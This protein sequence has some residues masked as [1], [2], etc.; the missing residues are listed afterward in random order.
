MGIAIRVV[1]LN[2]ATIDELFGT[3]LKVVHFLFQEPSP[4]PRQPSRLARL[5][6]ARPADPSPLCSAIRFDDD[7]TDVDKAWD[8]LDF[9]FSEG[10]TKTGICRFLTE[11][12][13]VIDND[14]CCSKPRAFRSG[15]V[16]EI[17][18]FFQSLGEQSLRK[19]YLP[20]KMSKIYPGIW[21]RDGDK[22]FE[23]ILRQ[24]SRLKPFIE[25]AA[26]RGNGILISE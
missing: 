23:Y 8:A 26:R 5:F 14:I 12:G 3:P 7:E 16:R 17:S 11:G 4:I 22:G 1:Q 10:R 6:G 20:R 13:Q 19:Y 24:F 18:E 9:L 25:M 21:K 2:D 15:Q